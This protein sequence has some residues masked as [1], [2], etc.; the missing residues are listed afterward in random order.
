[1]LT[2][3]ASLW[4][5]LDRWSPL[6]TDTRFLDEMTDRTNLEIRR[7]DLLLDPLEEGSFDFVHAR[8]VLEHLADPDIALSK[9]TR[10]LRPGGSIMIEDGDHVCV[11]PVS[12]LGAA[13]FAQMQSVRLSEFDRLG[14]N[15]AFARSLPARLRAQGLV[16]VDNEGRVNVMK[17]G[18][19]G[20]RW[21]RLS[22]AHLR[23]R[24]VGP[25]KLTEVELDRM[26]EL[27]EDPDWEAFSLLLLAV[28]GR[29]PM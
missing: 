9:L 19:A 13:E 10:A 12:E 15:H 7:H 14:V 1:M 8:L 4:V 28:W 5:R 25:G 18:S 26:L 27:F 20:A 16:N 2:G 23:G 11:V 29:C 17:G 6:D 24:L 3:C 21:A 22:V